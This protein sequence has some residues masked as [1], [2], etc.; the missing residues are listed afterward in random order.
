MLLPSSLSNLGVGEGHDGHI[1]R[2]VQANTR[3][4]FPRSM[5]RPHHPW[6]TYLQTPHMRE[7]RYLMNIQ[8]SATYVL[9][10]AAKLTPSL[11]RSSFWLG[12]RVSPSSPL[13]EPQAR[14]LGEGSRLRG[15]KAV[16]GW[17]SGA[18]KEAALTTFTVPG[19]H[20]SVCFPAGWLRA[21]KPHTASPAHP[22]LP[23]RLC[24]TGLQVSLD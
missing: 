3:R 14:L 17:I 13:E 5:G 19:P 9:L 7:K 16:S 8:A 10:C 20:G 11:T 12:D 4:A 2:M 23:S 18:Q 1:R 21:S 22:S 15:L 24:Y 6:M